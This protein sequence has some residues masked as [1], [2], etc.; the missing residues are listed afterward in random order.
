MSD[1]ALL[2]IIDEHPDRAVTAGEVAEQTD[3]TRQ[4][5]LKRLNEFAD[6]DEVRKK[7]VGGR[8][9]VWW[10][11]SGYERAIS[12]RPESESR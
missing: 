3:L 5:V 1:V 11:E 6:H 9:V 12:S 8:A 10:V 4:G 2:E 7:K